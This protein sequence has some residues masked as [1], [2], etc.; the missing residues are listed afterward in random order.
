MMTKFKI[1]ENK[2]Y[3]I[4]DY[5]LFLDP[6]TKKDISGKIIDIVLGEFPYRIEFFYPQKNSILLGLLLRNEIIR[7]LT[8]KEIEQFELEKNTIKYNL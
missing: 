1:F 8:S 3:K 5:V 6:D 7:K 4:G 2:E